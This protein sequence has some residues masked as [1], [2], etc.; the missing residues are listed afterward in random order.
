MSEEKQPVDELLDDIEEQEEKQEK[1]KKKTKDDEI[2]ELKLAL[3]NENDKALRAIAEL[4]NF[5]KRMTKETEDKI[6]YSNQLLVESL[7]P[8]IDNLDLAVTHIAGDNP[9]E[10]LKQGVELTLKQMKE[11]LGK[12]GFEEINLEAGEEFN[13]AEHE[14]VMLDESEEFEKN[15]VTGVMQKGYKLNGRVVRACKVK[16]NK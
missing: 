6:R 5:R 15:T 12:Y 3:K 1:P 11:V 2:N 10:S 7:I 9:L 13:P 16:V 4:D 8:V 14:A